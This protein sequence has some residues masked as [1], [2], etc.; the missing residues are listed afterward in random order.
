MKVKL[1]LMAFFCI[2]FLGFSGMLIAQTNLLQ[3]GNMESETGWSTSTLNSTVNFPDATWNNTIDAPTAGVDGNLHVTG[4]ASEWWANVQYAIYQPVTLSNTETY[5]FDGAFKALKYGESW[6][7]IFLGTKPEDGS[8]YGSGQNKIV[9]VGYWD[10]PANDDGTFSVDASTYSSF[11]PDT[12]GTYYFVLK[13]GTGNPDN[14]FE[15][16]V[17]ELSLVSRAKPIVRF[18]SNLTTAF[19]NDDIQFTDESIYAVSWSWD[20]GD[21]TTSTDQNP[22]HAYGASGKYTVT[23]EVT[24]ELGTTTRVMTDMIEITDPPVEVTAGG[25]IKGGEMESDSDWSI[26]YLDNTGASPAA[27]WNYT[28]DGPTAGTGGSLHVTA[29]G[30]GS[31]VQYAIYQPVHLSNDS[32]YSFEAA[33]KALSIVNSWC[34]VFIGTQPI[35]GLDYGSGQFVLSKFSQWG[36]PAKPDGTFSIDAAEYNRFIPD[37]TGIYYFVL[38]VGCNGDGNFEVILDEL[39]LT[40]SREKPYIAFSSPYPLGFAPL[41]VDFVNNTKFAVSY[42]WNFGDGSAVS[43]EENPTHVYETAGTYT[44]VLTATNELGDSTVSKADYVKANEKPVLPEGEK[45]YGGNMEDPNLWNIT[46]LNADIMPV[47]AVWN[48]TDQSAAHGAGGA[49]YVSGSV[50]NG[51]THYCIW[52]AVELHE[53]SVYHFDGAFRALTTLN[54]FWAEV[55]IGTVPPADGSDYGHDSIKITQFNTWASCTGSLVDGTFGN[56]G[57]EIVAGYQPETT[58][59]YYFV[60]KVGSGEWTGGETYDFEVI[61]DELTLQESTFAPAAVADFFSDITEGDAPLTVYFTDLSENATEWVWDFGDGASS[62]EQHPSHTYDD[63]GVYTVTLVASNEAN[64]DTLE[65]IDLITVNEVISV[66]S[67]SATELIVFPNPASDMITIASESMIRSAEILS[68]TGAVVKSLPGIN[69]LHCSISLNEFTG[70]IYFLRVT[71]DDAAETVVRI[72]K[73]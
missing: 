24:N 38:K 11:T 59:T 58:G 37:T 62:T 9:V 42:S 60:V 73:R 29:T 3:A 7:E 15:F 66:T 14:G 1:Q 18:S 68:V 2:T 50:S 10:Q 5:T 69:T 52:Q 48:Y 67:F 54:Q 41:T 70:G 16:I 26:S 49:L 36:Q 27:T 32:V 33:F 13:M 34:E 23:L 39:S 19:P 45:L 43:T 35:D 53:D 61:L 30:D 55:F 17:D 31:N 63:P 6:L 21:G 40:D 56:D 4:L 51:T 44:V 46:N 57:C 72:M 20:F 65:V 64:A 22:T 25:L 12:S 28:T 71:S 8:D 47:S